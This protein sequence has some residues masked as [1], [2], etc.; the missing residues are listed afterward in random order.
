[1][2]IHA[3]MESLRRRREDLL[4]RLQA[5]LSRAYQALADSGR[6]SAVAAAVNGARGGCQAP[7]PRSVVEALGQGA[8][9]ACARCER[10]LLPA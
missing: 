10:L 7:L 8:V 6:A 3:E 5:P 2:A 4:G 9:V 1:M